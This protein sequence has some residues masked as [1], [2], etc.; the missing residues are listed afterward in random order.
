MRLGYVR[1]SANTKNAEPELSLLDRASCDQ[2]LMDSLNSARHHLS[3]ACLARIET[4][5]AGD[6]LI[7]V[8]LDHLAPMPD[9][10]VLLYR[11]IER[12]ITVI[13]LSDGFSTRDERVA[14]V[15]SIL[16]HYSVAGAK[17][18][19]TTGRQPSLD[20]VTIERARQMI[21]DEHTSVA[22]VAQRLGVSRSTIYRNV[23]LSRVEKVSEKKSA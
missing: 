21:V 7:V 10:L 8:Q 18:K 20:E 3:P 15:F 13:S 12:G 11:L 5:G 23:P 6:E 17:P 22:D 2:V 19:R 4:M 14:E 1:I 16:G 9:L